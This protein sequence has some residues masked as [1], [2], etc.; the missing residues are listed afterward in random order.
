MRTVHLAGMFRRLL[1]EFNRP[2]FIFRLLFLVTPKIRPK[3]PQPSP[4][5]PITGRVDGRRGQSGQI[6][7][8]LRGFFLAGFGTGCWPR[9]FSFWSARLRISFQASCSFI[10]QFPNGADCLRVCG[11]QLIE[12]RM[13]D[14]GLVID[15]ARLKQAG[16]RVGLGFDARSRLV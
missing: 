2:V 10:S 4:L 8:Y 14:L 5:E 15:P 3:A 13:R 9:S 7:V 11:G 6:L 1:G 12:Q 16:Q